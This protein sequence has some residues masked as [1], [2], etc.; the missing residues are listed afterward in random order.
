MKYEIHRVMC[1]SNFK[2]VCE[3]K[4]KV[5]AL[6]NS[7]KLVLAN[8]VNSYVKY[9]NA[10]NKSVTPGRGDDISAIE[11]ENYRTVQDLLLSMDTLKNEITSKISD[12]S[13]LMQE[14]DTTIIKNKKITSVA[15]SEMTTLTNKA[16]GSTQAYKDALGLYR[17][18]IF[19][20]LVFIC[21][22]GGIMYMARKVF[23]ESAT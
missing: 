11:N 18:D 2:Y 5:D 13:K 7:V 21:A 19:K 3:L 23:M 6:E 4:G 8:F 12:N 17:K 16:D 15:S 14:M 20:N 10:V 22:S 1:D 9:Q